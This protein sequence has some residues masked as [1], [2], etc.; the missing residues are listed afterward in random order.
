MQFGVCAGADRAKIA[1]EAAGVEVIVFGS[2]GARRG[3]GN[4]VRR[5]RPGWRR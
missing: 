5:R 4:G 2:G 3:S 1:A